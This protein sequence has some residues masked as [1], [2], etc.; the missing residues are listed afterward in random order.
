[1]GIALRD[2]PDGSRDIALQALRR[3]AELGYAPAQ[4]WLARSADPARQEWKSAR[5]KPDAA[6]AFDGYAHAG[7]AANNDAAVNRIT[8]CGYMNGVS[9]VTDAERQAMTAYCH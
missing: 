5:A 6:V 8:L 4:L 7:P 3:A 9:Q 1:V 2:N